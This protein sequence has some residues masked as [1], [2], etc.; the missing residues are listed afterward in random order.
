MNRETTDLTLFVHRSE[1]DIVRWDRERIVE[2]LI[3]ETGVGREVAEEIS[4]EVERQ[5]FS[6]GISLLTSQ[7]IRELVDAKLIERGMEEAVRRH[8]RLGFPLYD[9]EQLLLHP[10]REQASVPHGPEG[11][12]MILAGGIKRDYA[13]YHVFSRSVADAHARG[14]IHLHDL[15][16]IDRIVDVHQP[17][18]ML[19]RQGLDLP[20]TLTVAR[21]AR[22]AEV[23]LAH[24]VRWSSIM[25][26]YVSGTVSW[27]ALNISFAL[28]PK[29]WTSGSSTNSP[30]CSFTNFPN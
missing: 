5:I 12:N 17:I 2:A 25:R 21:P 22:H 14:D 26:G 19:K 29:R 18:R 9:V 24:L 15:G 23:L 3:R 8:A 13:L 4:R 27:E 10:N 16:F 6:S 1:E 20:S 7:L 30:R 11:T 28:I